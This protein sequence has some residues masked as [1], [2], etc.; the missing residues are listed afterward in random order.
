MNR[1]RYRD[2]RAVTREHQDRVD[3]WV[4]PVRQVA[5]ELLELNR[6]KYLEDNPGSQGAE[7]VREYG[8]TGRQFVVLDAL[9]D[10]LRQ[11]DHRPCEFRDGHE[12]GREDAQ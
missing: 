6:R 2:P 1:H 4:D 10:A 8:W 7:T 5:L 3:Q 11:S 12:P 9:D